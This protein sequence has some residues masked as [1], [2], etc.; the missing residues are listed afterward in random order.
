MTPEEWDIFIAD[1][2]PEPG[3]YSKNEDWGERGFPYGEEAN[4]TYR[5][6]II[7]MPEDQLTHQAFFRGWM[8]ARKEL[9]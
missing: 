6:G 8:D 3:T 1:K 4:Y 5:Q 7:D 9:G 2:R